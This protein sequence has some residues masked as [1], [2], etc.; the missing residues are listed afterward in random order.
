MD[1]QP[2][3]CPVCHIPLPPGTTI[4]PDCKQDLSAFI[5]LGHQSGILYNQG[6]N[7][8]R[9]GDDETAI[10]Y[11]RKSLEEDKN[12]L[13]AALVLGKIFARR[14]EYFQAKTVW[15]Q[16]R[17]AHPES[18]ELQKQLDAVNEEIEIEHAREA[19]A[20]MD[21]VKRERDIKRRKILSWVSQVGL[22]F[23]FGC[24]AFAIY[25][26]IPR[27]TKPS[28]PNGSVV[29]VEISTLQALQ[30]AAALQSTPNVE[31][32]ATPDIKATAFPTP[33][34]TA[35]PTATATVQNIM[36]QINQAIARDPSLAGLGLNLI[37]SGN[38][39]HI[40]GTVPDIRTR[41]LAE[42]TVRN[43]AGVD[44]VD[45]SGLRVANNDISSLPPQ[46]SVD[47]GIKD[48]RLNLRDGPGTQYNV[49]GYLPQDEILKIVQSGEWYQVITSDGLVGWVISYYCRS[50][51]N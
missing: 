38:I 36:P 43:A 2:V 45:V 6:L 21:L 18:T 9:A 5:Y 51:E 49:I 14:K 39:I 1:N 27:P 25:Q 10:A 20:K 7:L 8:A 31:Q 26:N 11:L 34:P 28:T 30:T 47:V 22:A 12:N 24:A 42:L 50:V 19:Q 3:S 46:C 29:Q 23:I 17:Q 15:D 48:G 41:Y 13:P 35:I 37:Q 33:I 44:L 40:T 32:T 4:C 16:A